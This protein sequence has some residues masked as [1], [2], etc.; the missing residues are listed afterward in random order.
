MIS[1]LALEQLEFPKLL[2]WVVERVHCP[3]SRQEIL[4]LRP[5]NHVEEIHT[6]QTFVE[7][8]RRLSA[9]GNP[10][11][12][13]PFPDLRPLL[14]KARPE[15]AVL[16][17]LELAAFIDLLRL[18]RS[19]ARHLA[20]TENTPRLKD[21]AA[22]LQ[23]YPEL[24]ALLERALD[25]EGNV[26]DLASPWLAELRQEIRRLESQIRKRLEEMVLDP[27]VAVFL[28][29]QFVTQRSGRW[30]LPVRM[31]SKNQ[32]P[33]VVH[34][35]SRTGETAFVEPL[36]VIHLAN[37]LENLKAE[38]KA[39]VIRILRELSAMVRRKADEIEKEL[40]ILIQL[41]VI[42]ALGKM[43]DRLGMETPEIGR[44]LEIRLHRG[45]H[46]LLALSLAKEGPG[47]EVVPLDLELGGQATVMVITGVNAGGKTIALKTVG[48]LLIMALSGLPVPADS[49]SVFPM[50]E[51]L[52]V[53][54]G[55]EQSIESSLSTFSAHISRI[56]DIVHQ[57][58]PRALVLMDE[59]GT[60]TD[61]VEGAAIAC[62]VL[63]ELKE[64]GAL[65]L[66]T[67]HLTEIK[68]FVHRTEGMINAA[69]AFDE[70]NLIPLYQLRTG[71]PGRSH[72]LEIAR[73]YGLPEKILEN[74][75]RWMSG[76]EEGLEKLL[77][78]LQRKQRE[79][80]EGLNHL[81][82]ME[83]E[84]ARERQ[85]VELLLAEAET[86]KK[87]ILSEAYAQALAITDRTK[88]QMNQLWEEMK[89]KEKSERKQTL[90]RL[91]EAEQALQAQRRRILHPAQRGPELDTLRPGDPVTLPSLG[92][93]GTVIEVLTK[94][95]RVRVLA[96]GRD[97]EVSV[98]E[99]GTAEVRPSTGKTSP[100]WD[101]PKT[102]EVPLRLHLLGQRV[103]EALARLEPFLNHA[104][105]AGIAEVTIV[106][107]IGTGVLA[108]AV[109]DY[110]KGH[111]LV[112][113]FRKGQ[114]T[115]GGEGVTIVR[116]D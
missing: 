4:N 81:R 66:A 50:M 84:A 78:D 30:V 72:A 115:E 93:E 33:G 55:D 12:F 59:L 31:D 61:P 76:R 98:S 71:E 27:K 94:S 24:L 1:D 67:T 53:D 102:E 100:P 47:K 37:Q 40:L 104:A 83:E 46:P 87:E 10:L 96:G 5:L 36:Y 88:L 109:R 69:M 97:L 19:I 62:A 45:R 11:S 116:L 15:G 35:V 75:R 65:V 63:H 86:R 74:A 113:G 43:A 7:E 60:G 28:Q 9:E 29:D 13:F 68:G 57:A 17:P 85:R 20:E 58:D 8:V 48:L 73:R 6:R 106:H 41:D 2:Q 22:P 49:G 14:N 107:G 56:T 114:R 95:Q 82:R 80:E 89:K 111:P 108:R 18:S 70:Q 16:E 91:R 26:L 54:I 105:L 32:V 110:L 92:L 44:G 38:E 112:K 64:T 79:Y 90:R 39:E 3:A 52:L 101:R 51:K 77:A 21:L 23:G 99:L 25:A 103:D 34:D 42:Q